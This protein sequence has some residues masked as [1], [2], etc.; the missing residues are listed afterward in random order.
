LQDTDAIDP[1]P[2]SRI[3]L[4]QVLYRVHRHRGSLIR[5]PTSS[6]VTRRT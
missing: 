3:A 4:A 1:L 2:E 5:T 6:K